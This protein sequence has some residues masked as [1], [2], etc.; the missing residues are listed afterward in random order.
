[1]HTLLTI[2]PDGKVETEVVSRETID[3]ST[4]RWR[5]AIAPAIAHLRARGGGTC[6]V[7]HHPPDITY[8]V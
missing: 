6:L 4:N 7:S 1:M 8:R 3:V 5:A 2:K